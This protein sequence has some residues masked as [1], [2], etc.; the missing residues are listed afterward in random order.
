MSPNRGIVFVILRVIMKRYVIFIL[1][2][3]T[4]FAPAK[5]VNEL[6]DSAV[7]SLLT[8]APF[9]GRIWTVYGHTA[10]RVLDPA[11]RLDIAFNY[12]IFDYSKP[13]FIYRFTKGETDYQLGAQ[14]FND[15]MID[16]M[17]RGSAVTEQ[18]LNLTAKEKNNIW[19]ALMVNYQPENRVYRYNFF[20]DNCATRPKKI[21]ERGIE[22]KLTYP[23]Q[24]K[25]HSFRTLI[26]NCTKFHQWLTF[27]CDLVLGQPTDRRATQD[28]EM[29]LP[30]ILADNI[31]RATVTDSSGVARQLVVK[32]N[33]LSEETAE[34]LQQTFLD[35]FSPK[36]FGWTIFFI[37]LAITALG[38]YTGKIFRVT[39]YILF[40]AAG[41]GGCLIWFICFISTHP[42]V[43]P[44]WNALWLQPIHLVAVAL[45]AV[46]SLRKA[47]YIYHFVNFILIAVLIALWNFVPQHFNAAALPLVLSLWIRSAFNITAQRYSDVAVHKRHRT[48]TNIKK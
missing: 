20:F 22:G 17:M 35:T 34:P 2:F 12:G 26:N 46:P 30:T 18:V 43:W 13:H 45:F 25:H 1:L 4:F 44:N 15:F 48:K 21:I 7:V 36:V 10:I 6:S 11:N 27:G 33:Q 41:L 38:W 19:Q 5:A 8:V 37:I 29:F 3:L 24:A 40:G 47:G 9:Q 32:T 14:S 23:V 42:C 39:D 31:S 16:Y 28:E